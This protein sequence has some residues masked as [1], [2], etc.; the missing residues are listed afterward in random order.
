VS[1]GSIRFAFS[2]DSKTLA[3]GNCDHVDVIDVATGRN[4]KQLQN[5]EYIFSLAYSP[6]GDVLAVGDSTGCVSLWNPAS[7]QRV[8][9]VAVPGDWG[10]SWL[11]PG[12][13]LVVWGFLSYRL[14]VRRKKRA[15]ALSSDQATA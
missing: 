6:Q 8:W 7:G 14:W 1:P 12:I 3:A 10:V 13:M 15:A 9:V 5:D 2:P 4:I 11:T